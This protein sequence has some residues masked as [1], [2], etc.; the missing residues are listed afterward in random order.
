MRDCIAK[1]IMKEA[2][3]LEIR[4]PGQGTY[5][6]HG[7]WQT[8]DKEPLIIKG[9]VQPLT[10]KEIMQDVDAR[11]VKEVIKIYTPTELRTVDDVKKIQPDVVVYKGAEFEVHKVGDWNNFYKVIAIRREV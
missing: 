5:D 8:Q 4:R 11:H 7:R 9:A 6:E 1:A 3:S 10:P 2:I